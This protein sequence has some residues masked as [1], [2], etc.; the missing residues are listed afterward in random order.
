MKFYVRELPQ[1]QYHYQS[2]DIPILP[3]KA[4]EFKPG[5][6]WCSTWYDYHID[7]VKYSRNGMNVYATKSKL[8][9]VRNNPFYRKNKSITENNQ[10]KKIQGG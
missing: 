6:E 8:T 4:K 10:M 3:L 9:R 5:D 1:K 2:T 7:K